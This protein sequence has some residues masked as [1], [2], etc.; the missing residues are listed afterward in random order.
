MRLFV[1]LCVCPFSLFVCCFLVSVYS[2]YLPRHWAVG[3]TDLS[4]VLRF[5]TRLP[6]NRAREKGGEKRQYERKH[7]QNSVIRDKK[8]ER[9]R[10]KKMK[11]VVSVLGV[12]CVFSIVLFCTEPANAVLRCCFF[13]LGGLSPEVVLQ[14][15]GEQSRY[16]RLNSVSNVK[17]KKTSYYDACR[18]PSR[19]GGEKKK[20]WKH[21]RINRNENREHVYVL[22]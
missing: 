22:F 17:E 5:S 18:T 14:F 12:L 2:S 3:Q 15:G 20:R 7:S 13:H 1:L 19:P 9:K 8:K 6:L 4:L 11:M 21:Y 16:S 10:K